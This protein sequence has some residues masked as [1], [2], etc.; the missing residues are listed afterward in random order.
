MNKSRTAGIAVRQAAL[1]VRSARTPGGT[2]LSLRTSGNGN[3]GLPEAIAE[4]R[5]APLIILW[6]IAKMD[7]PVH[8]PLDWQ[9]PV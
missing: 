5:F 6:D 4:D 3:G 2:L 8:S 1:C 7:A 9:V